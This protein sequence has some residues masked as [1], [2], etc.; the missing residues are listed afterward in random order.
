[1]LVGSC[2]LKQSFLLLDYHDL[3]L[4][5]GPMVIAEKNAESHGSVREGREGGAGACGQLFLETELSIGGLL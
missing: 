5:I 2:S 1:M 3:T 4:V